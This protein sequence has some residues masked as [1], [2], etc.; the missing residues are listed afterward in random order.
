MEEE[1]RMLLEKPGERENFSFSFLSFL[2]L[3][4]DISMQCHRS[5]EVQGRET[6]GEDTDAATDGD[7]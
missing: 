6:E 5:F 7:H 4:F 2:F 1:L 3:I